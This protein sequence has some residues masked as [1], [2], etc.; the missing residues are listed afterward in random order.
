[1]KII[2][3]ADSCPVK[4]IAVRIAGENRIRVL[5]VS[6][7]A[8]HH[9]EQEGVSLKQVDAMPQEADMEIINS[10][11]RGDIVVTYDQGLASIVL[12]KGAGA[13][14]PDGTIFREKEI[15]S[16]LAVRELKRMLRSRGIRT[17][18]PKKRTKEQDKKFERN[19][20]RLIREISC[21]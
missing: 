17:K 15:D 5:M 3:D 8:H 10:S 9:P 6:S 19:L 21:L 13:L 1:M 2:I 18:G 16:L 12:A 7:I 20:S 4:E 14:S 11:R